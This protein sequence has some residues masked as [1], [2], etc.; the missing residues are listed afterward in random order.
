MAIHKPLP[1]VR[2]RAAAAVERP[3]ATLVCG[4]SRTMR[5]HS[6]TAGVCCAL[7]ALS[8]AHYEQWIG[9]TPT[10]KVNTAH[11]AHPGGAA[12]GWALHQNRLHRSLVSA[13]VLLEPF[14]NWLAA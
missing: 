5:W 2:Y 13:S 6:L 3:K 7:L 14:L 11:G 4:D 10:Q 8:C 9:V 1:V 12:V